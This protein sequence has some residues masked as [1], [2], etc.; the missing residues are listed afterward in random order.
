MTIFR[1]WHLLGYAFWF[2]WGMVVGFNLQQFKEIINKNQ[3][4]LT[5]LASY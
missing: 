3:T 4:D 1:D 5:H 2:V